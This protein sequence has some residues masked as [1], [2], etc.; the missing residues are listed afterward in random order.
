MQFKKKVQYLGH[1]INSSNLHCYD[2]LDLEVNLPFTV[3]S[4]SELS[5]YS[6]FENYH[7]YE[8]T[9]DLILSKSKDGIKFKVKGV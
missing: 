5:S 1:T 8:A 3:Y 6:K 4:M 7:N 2:F 9:F